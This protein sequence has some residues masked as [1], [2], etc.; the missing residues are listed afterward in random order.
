MASLQS[1]HLE[2]PHVVVGKAVAISLPP[3]VLEA[4]PP[5]SLDSFRVVGGD[6]V[7]GVEL[8]AQPARLFHGL[9]W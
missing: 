2:R 3:F 4:R 8:V 7:H 5:V 1:A 9:S 6:D